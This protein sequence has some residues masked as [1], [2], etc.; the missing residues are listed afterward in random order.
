MRNTSNQDTIDQ[1]EQDIHDLN[2]LIARKKSQGVREHLT[3]KQFLLQEQDERQELRGWSVLIKNNY[4]T[5]KYPEYSTR[6]YT[7]I[8]RSANEARQIVL[9]N[10][11]MILDE[12]KTKRFHDGRLVLP[13]SNALPITD[14]RIGNIVP[15]TERTKVTTMKPHKVLGPNG[16]VMVTFTN[17]EVTS[18]TDMNGNVIQQS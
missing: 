15:T 9:D 13:K 7:V 6:P 16:Y 1:I 11:D 17:G 2:D 12:L 18:V 5:G 10:A 8:A 4:Y 14:D 3:F